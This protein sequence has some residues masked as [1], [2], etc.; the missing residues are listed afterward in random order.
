MFAFDD[1]IMKCVH[2]TMLRKYWSVQAINDMRGD[3]GNPQGYTCSSNNNNDDDDD[4][5]DIDN[6]NNDDI[7]NDDDIKM[8]ILMMMLMIR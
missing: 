8:I 5:D 6:N 2:G 4:D 1:I 3:Y 7:D